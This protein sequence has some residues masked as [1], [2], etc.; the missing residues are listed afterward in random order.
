MWGPGRTQ[1][2]LARGRERTPPHSDHCAPPRPGD[3]S[4]CAALP[5]PL[6]GPRGIS[7]P[8]VTPLPALGPGS[9]SLRRGNSWAEGSGVLRA[10]PQAPVGLRQRPLEAPAPEEAHQKGRLCC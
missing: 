3:P 6:L 1:G 4:L 9:Q 2:A 7:H 8:S 10:D 5:W